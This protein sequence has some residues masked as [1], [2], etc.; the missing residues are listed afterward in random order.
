MLIFIK[1]VSVWLGN[2]VDRLRIKKIAKA[3][4]P[5][6]GIEVMENEVSLAPRCVFSPLACREQGSIA[7]PF[8]IHDQL[9][10]ELRIYCLDPASVVD[11][12][13]AKLP[14]R[15][16]LTST[17]CRLLTIKSVLI[18]VG[19]VSDI[20]VTCAKIAMVASHGAYTSTIGRFY[21][22]ARVAVV[23]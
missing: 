4:K 1:K 7:D 5:D 22:S 6:E 10:V 2:Y 13:A 14:A 3:V 21:P 17:A 8:P 19:T 16:Q 18:C 12:V 9:P 23:G 20:G 15:L 11:I